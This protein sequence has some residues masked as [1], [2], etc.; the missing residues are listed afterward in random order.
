MTE[1]ATQEQNEEE[2]TWQGAEQTTEPQQEAPAPASM[3][4][5]H[6][7][8]LDI[9]VE[10]HAASFPMKSRL[11]HQRNHLPHLQVPSQWPKRGPISKPGHRNNQRTSSQFCKKNDDTIAKCYLFSAK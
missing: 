2:E 11:K 6:D 3:T 9:L 7:Q 10:L 5:T 1:E 4:E 8:Q